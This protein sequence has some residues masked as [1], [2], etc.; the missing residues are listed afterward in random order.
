MMPLSRYLYV[1]RRCVLSQLYSLIP[2]SSYASSVSHV[3]RP[4]RSYADQLRGAD[5]NKKAARDLYVTTCNACEMFY[6]QYNTILCSISQ[7]TKYGRLCIT[8]SVNKWDNTDNTDNSN[9]TGCFSPSIAEK[10]GVWSSE[11]PHRRTN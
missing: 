11:Y 6:I 9:S 4:I 8:M 5:Y 7:S 2:N 3:R 10:T 1:D